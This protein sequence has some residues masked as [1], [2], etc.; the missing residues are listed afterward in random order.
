M[1]VD[2]NIAD[3]I[4]VLEYKIGSQTYNP[5]SYNGWTGEEGRGFKYPVNY[6][7]SKAD[8]EAHQLT[9]T[10]SRIDHLDPEC[11]GTMKYAFGSNHL[12]VGE[13]IVEVLK[14]LEEI[15]DIDFNKLEEKRIEKKKKALIEVEKKLS[16]G[17][18][19]RVDS[20]TQKVGLDIPAGKY[21]MINL[22]GRY[23]TYLSV[24]VYDADG[25]SVEHI[26]TSDDEVNVV[27]KE[28]YFTKSL[29]A[30]SLKRNIN[31]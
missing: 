14:Y 4:G 1:V 3:L 11:V 24:D 18:I 7:K 19:I 23:S 17:D 25:N 22:K 28:G 12:Y 5:N 9:K 15:Y 2:A 6:C 27:L 13:G 30:Y 26:F 8:L 31:E 21:K 10:K 16:E 29:D 20:G